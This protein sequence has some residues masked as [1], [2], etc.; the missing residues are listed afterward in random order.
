MKKTTLFVCLITAAA[1]LAGCAG[2]K[3][4]ITVDVEGLASSLAQETVN[5][6]SLTKA[7]AD[8]Q[9]VYFFDE[10]SYDSGVTYRSDGSIACEVAVITC[11]DASGTSDAEKKFKEHV[12]SQIEL[13]ESYNPAE[14]EKLKNAVIKSAGKYSVLCV[15]DDTGK[16]ESLLKEAGF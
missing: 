14:V 6:G 13:Y 1:L 10:N 7:A 9:T 5:S 15:C 2:K 4:D 3:K 8:P 12:D 11:K 16:A